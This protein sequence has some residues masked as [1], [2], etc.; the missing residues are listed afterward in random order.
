MQVVTPVIVKPKAI[1]RKKSFEMT[2]DSIESCRYPPDI[3][4][5]SLYA[6]GNFSELARYDDVKSDYFILKHT[7]TEMQKL[8]AK[9]IKA[10]NRKKKLA[11]LPSPAKPEQV[12][13]IETQVA[14]EYLLLLKYIEGVRI[15]TSRQR[16]NRQH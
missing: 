8:L 6:S 13:S 2:A 16:L 14:I 11:E 3:G 7:R 15:K 9:S 5:H 1:L 4:E 10:E 12:S